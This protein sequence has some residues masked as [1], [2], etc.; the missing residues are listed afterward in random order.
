MRWV[1]AVVGVLLAAVG[2][3][4]LIHPAYAP[5]RAPP[6][7]QGGFAAP[8]PP[9]VSVSGGLYFKAYIEARGAGGEMYLRCYVFD[10]YAGGLWSWSGQ[11]G[12]AFG[13]G[14]VTVGAGPLR[15]GGELNLSGPLMGSCVPVASPPVDGLAI[16]SFREVAPGARL[17]ADIEGLYVSLAGGS[18]RYVA[19]YIGQGTAVEKPDGRYLQVPPELRPVLEKIVANV[20]AGCRDAAC[21]ASRIKE[22]LTTGFKYDGTMDALWPE[23]PPGADPV[24]WFLTEGRR[25]VC[26][27]FASAFVLLARAAGVP[28]RLVI[29]YLSDGPVPQEW[30]VKAF[31]PHA[32]A[33]YYVEGVGWVGVEATPGGG[34]QIPVA[35]PIPLTALPPQPSPPQTPDLPAPPSP[36]LPT[37]LFIAVA[38]AAAAASLAVFASRRYV[39]LG[40]GEEFVV[41]GPP[42]FSVYVNKRRVGR[43]PVRLVFD[44]PGLYLVRAGPVIYLVRVL[45]YKRLAGAIYLRV[46]RRLGLPP[47][48][49]PRELAAIRP[50]YGE[51]ALIFER[52]RFGPSAGRG[53]VERLRRAL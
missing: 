5:G 3:T 37:W 52:I 22:Y 30:S 18:P 9:V 43:P 27:H 20:T 33:E 31:S 12:R 15:L 46:L 8:Q 48:V 45:D 17:S 49:T 50:E 10:T 34:V 6:F 51:F 13:D 1:L 25:G 4:S 40:L 53:D 19:S 44:K 28:A 7:G 35:P 41:R 39:T 16:G 36:A 29:G 21:A 26:I 42:W 47:T 23:I 32:W 2:L 38:S 11:G 24:L 14:V